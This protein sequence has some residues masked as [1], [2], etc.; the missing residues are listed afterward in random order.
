MKLFFDFRFPNV[1]QISFRATG[2]QWLGQ[3]HALAELRG[4][5]DL[6]ILPEGNPIHTKIWREYAVYRL[7]HWGLK[8]INDKSVSYKALPHRNQFGACYK[9]KNILF[10]WQVTDEE[11]KSAN[12]TYHGLSDIVLRAL[13]DAPLQPLLSR[14]GRSGNSS[15]SAKAWLRAADPALRDV[16]AK[17]ALQYKKGHVSQVCFAFWIKSL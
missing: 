10:F 6:T 16:I 15:V 9:E 11:V 5:S 4:I 12:Q 7:A 2:L 14:L 13:P 1:S 3:L 8:Q 17:E